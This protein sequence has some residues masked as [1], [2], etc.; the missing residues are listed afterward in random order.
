MWVCVLVSVLVYSC[1]KMMFMLVCM[2]DFVG[3]VVVC[4]KR[5]ERVRGQMI[6]N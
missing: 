6:C 2:G 4:G 3:V 1:T 5:G